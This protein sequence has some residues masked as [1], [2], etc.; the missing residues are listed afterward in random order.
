MATLFIEE[1]FKIFGPVGVVAVGQ[2]R[3]DVIR[4]GMTASIDGKTMVVKTIQV[5]HQA[6]AEA[7]SGDK[8]GV[9][10]ANADYNAV[11]SCKGRDLEFV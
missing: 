6:V 5:R 3:S 2:V 7:K 10:L 9:G 8:V 11:K 4:V 1:V